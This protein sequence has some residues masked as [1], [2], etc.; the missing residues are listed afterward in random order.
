MFLLTIVL[1]VV[2]VGIVYYVY[3]VSEDEKCSPHVI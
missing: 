1:S 3:V 2:G